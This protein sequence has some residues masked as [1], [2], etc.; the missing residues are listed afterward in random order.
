[1]AGDPILRAR[2]STTGHR[3][4]LFAGL[5]TLIFFIAFFIAPTPISADANPSPVNLLSA[6]FYSVLAGTGVDNTGATSLNADLG[7]SPSGTIASGLTVGGTTYN[8][9]AAIQAQIDASV[10]YDNVAARAGADFA[11]DLI[12]RTFFPGVY[13]AS[14]AITISGGAVTL[15]GQGNSNSVFI[16]N[17][18]AALSS[19]AS[20]SVSL[21]NNAQPGNVFWRTTGAVAIGAGANFVGTTLAKGA[22]SMGAGASLN[23]RALSVGTVSLSGNNIISTTPPGAPTGVIAVAGNTQATVSWSAPASN[24]GTPVTGYKVTSSGGQ[25]ATTAGATTATV[26]GLTNGTPQTFT[27][28][29]TNAIG[30][31]NSSAAS[32][33]VTPSTIPGAPTGVN[34]VAGNTEATVSWSAPASNGGTAITG[35]TITSSGGQTATTTGATITTVNGLTNGTPYTFTV[36][37]TNA[38]GTSITSTSS[39]AVSPAPGVPSAPTGVN[40]VAGVTQATVSWTTPTSTG[41]SVI[42]AYTVTASPGG[43]I[44]A[45]NGSTN[46]T[47]VTGLTNGTA[48]TFT[49]TATNAIGTSSASAASSAVT[50]A[51]TVPDS[52]TGVVA[53][54]GNGQASV[55]WSAPAS[56]GGTAI[57]GYTVTASSGQVFAT[58]ST[59]TTVTGLTNGTAYTFTV[60]ATN[61]IGTSTASS[62]SSAVTPASAPGVPTGVNAVAGNTQVTVSW[63][64]P[65][66]TGGTAITGYTVTASSGQVLATSSTTTTVTGLTNG[67]PYTFTVTATNAIGTSTASSPSSAVTPASAPGVPTG[68]NAVAGNTQVTVSWSAPANT[69]GT[70]ITGYTVTSSGGQVSTTTGATTTTVTALTNGTAYTFTVTATNAIGMSI[71]SSSSVAV[72]PLT[73]PGPPTSVTATAGN[74]QASI[75]WAAPSNTGGSAITGY[76]V[77][78]TPGSLTATTTGATTVMVPGLT[79]GTA[80]TFTVTATNSSGTSPA[81]SASTSITPAATVPVAPT[82]VAATA[83]NTQASVWWT[84]SANAGSSPITEYTVTSSPGSLTATTTGATSVMV[85]GLTNGTTYTFTVTAKNA[86]G[87][88]TASRA[89][90]DVIPLSLVPVAPTGVTASAGN[91]QVAVWWEPS[92]N[93]GGSAITGYTVTATPGGLT[94]T[95]IGVTTSSANISGLTNGTPYTFTV[96]ANNSL[97]N[98]TASTP[99]APAIPGSI[100]P[101]APTSVSATAG[102][103]QAAIWWSPSINGGSSAITGYTVTSSGGQ[104]TTTI[105]ASTDTVNVIGLTNGTSYTFTVTAN[106]ATSSSNASIASNSVTPNATP[107]PTP[108]PGPAPAPQPGPVSP[109]SLITVPGPP[110]GVFVT[111]GNR[112]AFVR[113]SA[114][115]NDGGSPI[116]RYTVTSSGGQIVST[117]GATTATVTGLTDGTDYTFT[118]TA[119]NAV[120]TSTALPDSSPDTPSA[121]SNQVPKPS[122]IVFPTKWPPQSKTFVSLG[123]VA[124]PVTTTKDRREGTETLS[125][126][127]FQIV[128]GSRPQPSQTR[129]LN[130]SGTFTLSPGGTLTS[131]GSGFIA[132]TKIDMYLIHKNVA[133]SLGKI[134]V[135]T[136]GSYAGSVRVPIDITD[137]TYTLQVN[138]WLSDFQQDPP[139]NQVLTS[140]ILAKVID[141]PAKTKTVQTIV[142][143]VSQSSK[144]NKPAK[145]QLDTLIARMPSDSKNVITLIGFTPPE[146]A[147]TKTIALS[148]DRTKSVERYLMSQGVRGKF[149]RTPSNN[150]LLVLSGYILVKVTGP[151]KKTTPKPTPQP[152][153][154]VLPKPTNKQNAKKLTVHFEDYSAALSES[155]KAQI[156]IMVKKLPNKSNNF[157]RIVGFVS[158]GGSASHVNTLSNARTKSVAKY[159]KSRGV[160]GTY[161]REAAGNASGSG[162]KTQRAKIT[163]YPNQ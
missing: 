125:G 73:V 49:V 39:T 77:T 87:L 142:H 88:S 38:N 33:A 3:K 67:T 82:G 98:S 141:A 135:T 7:L 20:T 130:S 163:I 2:S 65:A 37:A 4:R 118:V 25:I 10:A 115:A 93:A 27:I 122:P 9:G 92:H 153:L 24:G 28:V 162:S 97:G 57:T 160:R 41:G 126:E 54:P 23:G 134:A 11:G 99:S 84:A 146:G 158:A 136:D 148:N 102:N 83:G 56:T 121:G 154:I 144:L 63:S 81:S 119:T 31:S 123:G 66:N 106:N 100:V 133:V 139:V 1:M 112:Q 14:G 50:P 114:P 15:D 64:A 89:S 108:G 90:T 47:T 117:T 78:S 94:T 70:A 157:I 61:A 59:T 6:G 80:Y 96:T 17:I 150:S 53:T 132:G 79:N 74:G 76:S 152:D 36:T 159:L 120:G 127:N 21:I 155:E 109:S 151:A 51:A 43:Q 113:W 34:A 116:T 44:V 12:G 138:G 69:G 143:F 68:V 91:T 137:D 42:T 156:D 124:V 129:A 58:S 75:W 8:G 104:T 16:F 32:S 40:A 22:V 71:A 145:R 105:G 62:P 48:Y 52:P 18:D 95:V 30:T 131:S 86:S 111:V 55:S 85:P 29:A 140:T 107:A 60:T 161:V 128:L 5:T 72:T 26:T 35:Y 103:N 13:Y 45:T 19:A 101:V 110:T 147:S 149:I 46:T